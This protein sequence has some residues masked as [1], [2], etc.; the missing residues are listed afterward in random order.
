MT[1][2]QSTGGNKRKSQ[3]VDGLGYEREDE[4][5]L[6][7]G[8]NRRK[9]GPDFLPSLAGQLAF[10]EFNPAITSISK[11]KTQPLISLMPGASV[12]AGSLNEIS[13]DAEQDLS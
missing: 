8:Q 3:H 1:R 5:S 4:L 2:C 7:A 10:G 11:A 6:G 13:H 12:C 9:M